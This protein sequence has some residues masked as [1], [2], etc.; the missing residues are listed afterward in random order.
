MIKESPSLRCGP[1]ICAERLPS[2]SDDVEIDFGFWV[3]VVRNPPL[4]CL[5]V[6]EHGGGELVWSGGDNGRVKGGPGDGWSAQFPMVIG[7][8]GVGEM[9]V[10]VAITPVTM[11][12]CFP[13]WQHMGDHNGAFASSSVRIYQVS[14]IGGPAS[15]QRGSN[16][17]FGVIP[18]GTSGAVRYEWYSNKTVPGW[19]KYEPGASWGGTMVA[20]WTDMQ[21]NVFIHCPYDEY[22]QQGN[23]W[24][25]VTRCRDTS[26]TPRDWRISKNCNSSPED[27]WE[28]E[29]WFPQLSGGI[30]FPF[31]QNTNDDAV[32]ADYN[33]VVIIPV[34]GDGVVPPGGPPENTST[35]WAS[36][37]NSGPNDGR[38]YNSDVNLY[39]VRRKVWINKWAKPDSPAPGWW[40]AKY[41]NWSNWYTFND[42][43]IGYFPLCKLAHVPSFHDGNIAHET[44]GTGSDPMLKMLLGH[45]SRIEHKLNTEPDTTDACKMVE[46]HTSDSFDG[47]RTLNEGVRGTA[48]LRLYL[49]SMELHGYTQSSDCTRHNWA[50]KYYYWTEVNGD[51]QLN[52]GTS[53]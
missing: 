48:S 44:N 1:E 11:G 16:A 41:P 42:A 12:S 25:E 24:H 27:H 47:L 33:Q 2:Q 26:C 15:V 36:R 7:Y 50:G 40:R 39:K 45:W 20:D 53:F 5:P 9:A 38:W 18:R 14:N 8:K 49:Y 29:Q 51:P 22:Q 23:S 6:C 35:G 13:G 34:Y 3:T 10:A 31:G 28:G 52:P 17:T 19:Q 43:W 37:V 30:N 32:Y 21:V 4:D 46:G